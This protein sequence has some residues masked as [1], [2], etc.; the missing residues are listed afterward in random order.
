VATLKNY[1]RTLWDMQQTVSRKLGMDLRTAPYTLRVTV[2]AMDA[3]LAVVIKALTDKGVITDAE[4]NASV[5]ALR[6]LPLE[7]LEFNPP[8]LGEDAGEIPPPGP[9]TGA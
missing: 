2:L 6:N 4:L 7:K 9:I 8:D 5:Q 1:C 3:A